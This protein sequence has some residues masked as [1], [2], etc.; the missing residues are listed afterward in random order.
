MG[1]GD[2][3]PFGESFRRRGR[4]GNTNIGIRDNSS[5]DPGFPLLSFSRRFFFRDPFASLAAMLS[6]L[7]H[8]ITGAN[9]GCRGRFSPFGSVRI[10]IKVKGKSGRDGRIRTGGPLLPKRSRGFFN[11]FAKTRTYENQCVTDP[12]RSTPTIEN[13]QSKLLTVTKWSQALDGECCYPEM[14]SLPKVCPEFHTTQ[15]FS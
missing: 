13:T 8:A 12:T 10:C 14:D 15:T 7:S 6:M 2:T 5:R 1:P 4:G 9:R 11:K 3:I